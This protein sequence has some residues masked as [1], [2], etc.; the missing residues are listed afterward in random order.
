LSSIVAGFYWHEWQSVRKLKLGLKTLNRRPTQVML[1]FCKRSGPL[2]LVI[3]GLLAARLGAVTIK[4]D[5]QFD[6]GGFFAENTP[7]GAALKEATTFYSNI[8][9]DTLA[10]MDRPTF[11]GSGG[12]V[13][14]DWTMQ[15]HN[16]MNLAQQTVSNKIIGA[17]EFL[18][19]PGRMN[20]PPG[21]LAV[22]TFAGVN[23]FRNP[24][25]GFTSSEM[26]QITAIDVSFVDAVTRRGEPM[27]QFAAS[28]GSIS[29]D[30]DANWH[31]DVST[32]PPAGT[33][34][35]YSVAI[36]ELAHT[37]GIGVSSTWNGLVSNSHFIGSAA[38]AL[39][40]GPVPL[41][42]G[43]SHWQEGLGSTVYGGTAPQAAALSPGLVMGTRKKLTAIDAAALSDL[44]WSLIPPPHLTGDYNGDGTVNAADYTLWRNTRGQMGPGLPADGDPNNSI[45][46]GDYIVWKQNFGHTGVFGS[47]IPQAIPEPTTIM[48]LIISAFGLVFVR[49][50]R[51][52][53]S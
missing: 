7:A 18:I 14:W 4:L 45:D 38:A 40:G 27:P 19:F 20:H 46:A 8:L 15:V 42:P 33:N 3:V 6:P 12:T 25:S 51:R 5:Y 37:L 50:C 16:P 52:Q 35:F 1:L 23:A 48:Q 22:A 24:V 47:V 26:D 41:A 44:G 21:T 28:G 53:N 17:D 32:P 30:T 43:N 49:P 39:H 34:D 31:Y 9:N 13:H 10:A 36:H 11:S 29:F 2:S